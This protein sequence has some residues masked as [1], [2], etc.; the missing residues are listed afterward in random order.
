MKFKKALPW[1][2]VSLNTEAHQLGWL[3]NK[4]IKQ[5]TVTNFILLI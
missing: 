5:I 2:R 3:E 4:P 1:T